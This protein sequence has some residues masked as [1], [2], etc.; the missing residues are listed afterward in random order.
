MSHPP[1]PMTPPA[2]GHLP[3]RSVGRDKSTSSTS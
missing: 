2:F 3:T 1:L